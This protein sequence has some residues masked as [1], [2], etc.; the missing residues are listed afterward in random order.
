MLPIQYGIRSQQKATHVDSFG[1][2]WT[3]M[4]KNVVR[5]RQAKPY[6][7]PLPYHMDYTDIRGFTSEDNLYGPQFT[8]ASTFLW[9][10]AQ[11]AEV[12]AYNHAYSKLVEKVR[13]GEQVQVAMNLAT[14]GMTASLLANTRVRISK[15]VSIAGMAKLLMSFGDLIHKGQH[16]KAVKLLNKR[17]PPSVEKRLAEMK[18]TGKFR[19]ASRDVSQEWL[20]LHFA[21]SPLLGD[22]W[23][24]LVFLS[25]GY[26]E[27]PVKLDSRSR[28][29]YQRK[30]TT[31]GTYKFT[32]AQPDKVEFGVGSV[33]VRLGCEAQ[34]TDVPK[35]VSN[36][37]GLVN[38]ALVAWDLVPFS[39]VLG[40]CANFE[41]LLAAPTDFVGVDI[42]NLYHTV[43]QVDKTTYSDV[44]W[45][46]SGAKP[47]WREYSHNGIYRRMDRTI[48]TSFKYPSFQLTVPITS[49]R[50]ALAQISLLV[51]LGVSPAERNKRK[52]PFHF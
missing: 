26:T 34:V 2:N 46:Y 38:P 6:D 50:R 5:A 18:S 24:S 52:K 17:M 20:M 11:K 45:Q 39:F 48:P 27:A 36:R 10:D 49:W 12:R 3:V 47:G 37:L 9:G 41:Q 42:N 23:K 22:M 51:L 25:Q 1:Q 19:N 40:W 32:H 14:A 21:W 16:R 8:H 15:V 43:Y 44:Q 30:K 28:S 29:K 33:T 31:E 13:Q 7:R 35:F 4:E